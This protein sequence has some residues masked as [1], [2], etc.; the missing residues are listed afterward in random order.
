VT[1]APDCEAAI[2]ILVREKG[3]GESTDPIPTTTIIA[4]Q[5]RMWFDIFNPPKIVKK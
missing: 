2:A 4:R 1:R 5:R 3:G